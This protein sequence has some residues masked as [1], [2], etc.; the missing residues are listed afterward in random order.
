M[1]NNVH[2]DMT[3]TLIDALIRA[4]RDFDTIVM[5]NRN[6]GFANDPWFM[7]RTW[8]YFVDHLLEIGGIGEIGG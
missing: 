5:P 6:H 7:R 8:D 2:P 4:D 1:D 3:I